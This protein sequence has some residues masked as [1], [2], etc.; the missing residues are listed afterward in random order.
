MGSQ[1]E[2]GGSWLADL[3]TLGGAFPPEPL[4]ET[5]QVSGKWCSDVL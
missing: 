4:A 1:E 2:A 3:T 5:L